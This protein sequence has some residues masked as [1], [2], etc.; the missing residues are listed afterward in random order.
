MST[1]PALG[2]YHADARPWAEMLTAFYSTS[3]HFKEEGPVCQ[4]LMSPLR[5]DNSIIKARPTA[6]KVEAQSGPPGSLLANGVVD[7]TSVLVGGLCKHA[8]K[9]GRHQEPY[10][11]GAYLEGQRS[12]HVTPGA[13]TGSG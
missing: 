9:G 3:P 4:T 5:D 8:A 10:D 11:K 1:L 6:E 2:P 12:S 7:S 13:P